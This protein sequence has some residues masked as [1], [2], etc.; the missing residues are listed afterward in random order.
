MQIVVNNVE[1]ASQAVATMWLAL[2]EI[3]DHQEY[4]SEFDTLNDWIGDLSA[5]VPGVSRQNFFAKVKAYKEHGY[6]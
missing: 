1:T 2:M 4:L 3:Y 6:N 5:R